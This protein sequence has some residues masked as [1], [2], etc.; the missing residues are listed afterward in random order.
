LAPTQLKKIRRVTGGVDDLASEPGMVT[1]APVCPKATI[2]ALSF[3]IL[4]VA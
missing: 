3:V 1:P 2:P 4:I